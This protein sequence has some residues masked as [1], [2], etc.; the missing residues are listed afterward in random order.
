MRD[1]YCSSAEARRHF[2]EAPQQG[3]VLA[4]AGV[5]IGLAA[6]FALARVLSG[7]LFGVK[8]T[9]PATLVAITLLLLSVALVSCL[10][11]ARRATK[12]DLLVALRHE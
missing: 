8:A 9:D 7:L 1:S 6:S 12:V 2:F 4:V 10:I 3:M 5:A 11:R